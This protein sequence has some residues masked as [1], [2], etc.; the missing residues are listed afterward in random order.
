VDEEHSVG[1]R[2]SYEVADLER[3]NLRHADAPKSGCIGPKAGMVPSVCPAQSQR[4]RARRGICD[5]AVGPVG[6]IYA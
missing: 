3:L 6:P 1:A 4:Q 5:P 2:C